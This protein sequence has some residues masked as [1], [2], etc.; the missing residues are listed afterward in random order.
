MTTHLFFPD[1]VSSGGE[2]CEVSERLHEIIDRI[3]SYVMQSIM[4][5]YFARYARDTA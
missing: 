2:G 1:D 3:T 5:L 4:I